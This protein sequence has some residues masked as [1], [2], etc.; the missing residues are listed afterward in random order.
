[1]KEGAPPRSEWPLEYVLRP[2]TIPAGYLR[3]S[4]NTGAQ[5][6]DP[7][8]R[9]IN[10]GT[11]G[12]SYQAGATMTFGVTDRVELSTYVPKI[13]CEGSGPVS[14][15]SDYAR[16]SGAGFGFAFGVVRTRGVQVAL[17]VGLDVAITNPFTIEAW[18]ST[19]AK[20]LLEAHVSLALGL[21]VSHWIDAARFYEPISDYASGYVEVDLQLTRH[22]IAWSAL[23]PGGPLRYDDQRRLGARGGLTWTF[24]NATELAASGGVYNVLPRRPEDLWVPGGSVVVSLRLWL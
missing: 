9:T 20:L 13:F 23:E 18:A 4:V 22:L 12:S 10:G 2:Q 21:T 3:L 7:S 15:C 11:Y 19:S 5:L 1:V 6:V 8:Y 17:G 14:A 24:E 16:F